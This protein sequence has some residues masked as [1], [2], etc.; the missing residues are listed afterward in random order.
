VE[1]AVAVEGLVK[2]Y[3]GRTV[4]DALSFTILQ[5]EVFALLGPNGAGKTTTVECLTGLRKPDEGRL[6]VC[7]AD[8]VAER[9]RA[10]AGLGV[11]LQEGGVHRAATP[12]ELLRL[13]ASLYPRPH[14]P[15]AL[16]HRLGVER[17]ADRRVRTLSVGERQRVSLALALIGRPR[18]A[19]LDE[20]TAA[21]DPAARRRVW[22]LVAELRADGVAVLLTTHS[23]EEAERLA[24]VV[25]VLDRGHLVAMDSPAALMVGAGHGLLVDTP[26]RFDPDEL[27]AAFGAP[28]RPDGTGRWVVETDVGRM[29]DVVSWFADRG[30][31]IAGVSTA[32][33]TL[34]DVYLRLTERGRD[35]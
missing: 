28:V 9:D 21:M 26:A 27:A 35:R 24:D 6:R 5:G 14:D 25:A 19:I 20:P 12:R 7:G 3:G 34:E 17:L 31:P 33:R 16:L 30:L 10:V 29:A 32:G 11:M 15:D 2:R 23:M 8:P 22:D 13:F 18:V 1:P 4:V